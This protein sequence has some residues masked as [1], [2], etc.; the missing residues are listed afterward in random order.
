MTFFLGV[1]LVA[2]A[3]F[4][5]GAITLTVVLAACMPRSVPPYTPIVRVSP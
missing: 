3:L 1:V 5:M 2:G 4:V